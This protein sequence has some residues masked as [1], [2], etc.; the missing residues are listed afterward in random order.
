MAT[1]GGALVR[2]ALVDLGWAVVCVL[3]AVLLLEMAGAL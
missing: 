3:W 2:A 1:K